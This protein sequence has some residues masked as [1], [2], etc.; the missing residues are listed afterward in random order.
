MPR[1]NWAKIKKLY[2]TKKYP[3]IKAMCE[4][5]GID[6]VRYI[7]KQVSLKGWPKERVKI[8]TVAEE[9]ANREIVE[10]LLE[11]YKQVQIRHIKIAKLIQNRSVAFLSKCTEA[12]CFKHA[13]MGAEAS[14]RIENRAYGNN[15]GGDAENATLIINQQN[16]MNNQMV[17]SH[18][19][20]IGSNASEI[21]GILGRAGALKSKP[22]EGGS[23][24]A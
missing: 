6:K 5:E 24:K 22:E 4:A 16:T 8:H 14:T 1:Y 20:S 2:M 15:A 10:E 9:Q 21:L 11:D 12:D 17:V 23:P 7:E 19:E 13:V 3:T 18:A